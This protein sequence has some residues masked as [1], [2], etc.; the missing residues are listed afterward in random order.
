MSPIVRSY[1]Q[2]CSVVPLAVALAVAAH[3][4][5]TA[6][7]TSPAKKT[8]TAFANLQARIAEHTK[9]A[10]AANLVAAKRPIVGTTC[11]LNASTTPS[12]QAGTIAYRTLAKSTAT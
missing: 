5:T 10:I 4:A 7:P 6:I 3:R 11:A 12:V 1:V 9:I 2:E 8:A